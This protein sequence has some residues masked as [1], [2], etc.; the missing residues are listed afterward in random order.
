MD[1]TLEAL[2]QEPLEALHKAL[3]KPEVFQRFLRAKYLPRP[4]SESQ[5]LHPDSQE[6]LE[7][8][9]V[10]EKRI[11]AAAWSWRRLSDE[12]RKVVVQVAEKLRLGD[13]DRL[14]EEMTLRMSQMPAPFVLKSSG[15]RVGRLNPHAD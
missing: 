7:A 6:A 11:M 9:I 14:E 15:D 5:S 4:E 13:G 3:R 10:D 8:A 12:E 1:A 2:D